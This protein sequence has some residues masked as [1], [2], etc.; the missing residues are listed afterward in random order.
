MK[1]KTIVY[2]DDQ[3]RF[4]EQF[5]ERHR[6]HYDIILVNDTRDLLVTLDKLK[7]LP[8]LVLLDLFHPREDDPE[9]EERVARAE[10]SLADLDRQIEETGRIVHE[11]W[12]PSGLD[13]LKLIRQKYSVRKLPVVIYTQKGLVLLGDNEL[14]EAEENGADWLLKKKLSARTEQV[15]ID[16]IIMRTPD[17]VAANTERNYRW[18]LAFSWLVIGLLISWLIFEP[19]QFNDITIGLIVAVVTGLV[20]YLLSPLLTKLGGKD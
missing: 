1:M 9:F 5:L 19:T 18:L 15:A 13:I 2:C 4:R 14:R 3:A 16:R 8:D 17:R 7:I 11:A 20:T 10:A 12:E 6:D